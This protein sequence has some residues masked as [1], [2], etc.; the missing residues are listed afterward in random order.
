MFVRAHHQRIA[1]VLSRLNA[2]LLK[3]NA[4]YFGG[5]TAIALLMNEFRESVDLDFMTSDV[6]RYRQLR[7]L[8]SE[9]EGLRA[10]LLDDLPL[11]SDVRMDQYG[12]RT[13]VLVDNTP[14]KFEI[15][16]EGRI[17]FA[18][19]TARDEICGVTTLSRMDLATRKMLANADR[20]LDASSFTRDLIDLAMMNLTRSQL[21]QAL[22]KAEQAYSNSV[23]RSLHKVLILLEQQPARLEQNMK[24]MG[25]TL[26]QA[27]L[28][29]QLR[30][31]KKR[32]PS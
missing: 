26:P 8:V 5:G 31:L 9:G 25:M 14:I 17:T 11:A 28:W 19:P 1:T 30:K 4:C 18:Q 20:G 32:L 10:L 7:N 12:I 29:Q 27:Q 22:R 15:V 3:E 23:S 6:T 13:I 16:L 24:R 2:A 21:A